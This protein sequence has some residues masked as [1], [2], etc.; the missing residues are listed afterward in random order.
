MPDRKNAWVI[1]RPTD[2]AE[3]RAMGSD[4]EGLEVCVIVDIAGAKIDAIRSVGEGL[5]Y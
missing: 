5:G 2:G 1:R 3:E 4:N